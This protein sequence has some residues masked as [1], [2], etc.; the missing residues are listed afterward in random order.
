LEQIVEFVLK[1]EM[2][3]CNRKKSRPVVVGVYRQFIGMVFAYS[4]ELLFAN[5]YQLLILHFGGM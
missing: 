1:N 3:H 4:E 5:T 2:N